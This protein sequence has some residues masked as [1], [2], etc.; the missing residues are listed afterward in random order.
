MDA[1]ET[2]ILFYF[3]SLGICLSCLQCDKLC[4]WRSVNCQRIDPW[5]FTSDVVASIHPKQCSFTYWWHRGLTSQ[6]CHQAVITHVW[7]Q[8]SNPWV[9]AK[10][11][12]SLQCRPP[13][14]SLADGRSIVHGWSL[15]V[16]I[17]TRDRLA[18]DSRLYRQLIAPFKDT[19]WIERPPAG[20]LIA[21]SQTVTY[22]TC[23]I[24][25]FRSLNCS[26]CKHWT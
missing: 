10:W 9:T 2:S 21:S 26:D 18:R 15:W 13:E 7:K 14:W 12:R 4:H 5:Q 6:S 16:V 22:S 19:H 8:Y 20:W 24:F 25:N 1:Q 11:P 3:I 17:V 23:N